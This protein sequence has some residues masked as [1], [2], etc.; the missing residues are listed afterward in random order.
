MW[1]GAGL[2]VAGIASTHIPPARAGL[3]V[4]FRHRTL[5]KGVTVCQ[6]EASGSVSSG[7]CP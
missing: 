1:L 7:Y 2:E 6:V 4:A 5:G 3:S